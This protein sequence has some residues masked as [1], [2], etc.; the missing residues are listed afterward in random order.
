MSSSRS[1]GQITIRNGPRAV[2][3]MHSPIWADSSSSASEIHFCSRGCTLFS[4]VQICCAW[5]CQHSATGDAARCG[6]GPDTHIVRIIFDELLAL[7]RI[8]K[9]I[10]E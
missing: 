1:V 4:C 3:E 6:M 2:E 5:A 7:F 8:V 9:H 10:V